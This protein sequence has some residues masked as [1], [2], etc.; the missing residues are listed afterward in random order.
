MFAVPQQRISGE[1]DHDHSHSA[2][3]A[4]QLW[5]AYEHCHCRQLRLLSA[6]EHMGKEDTGHRFTHDAQDHGV[7][8]HDHHGAEDVK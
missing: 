3:D 8:G 1:R 7:C 4:Q 5:R 2:G 6:G